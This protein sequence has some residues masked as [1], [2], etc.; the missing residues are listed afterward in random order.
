MRIQIDQGEFHAVIACESAREVQFQIASWSQFIDATLA[1]NV[2]MALISMAD[3]A[4]VLAGSAAGHSGELAMY[5]I[6]RKLDEIA[7]RDG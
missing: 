5:N 6:Q 1:R 2:G 7:R 3:V 4:G